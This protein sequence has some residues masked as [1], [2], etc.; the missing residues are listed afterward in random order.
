M[1][2]ICRLK[3]D[4]EDFIV[5][6]KEEI[7]PEDFNLDPV[8]QISLEELKTEYNLLPLI[9]LDEFLLRALRPKER[10]TNRILAECGIENYTAIT[11]EKDLI[12]QKKSNLSRSQRELVLKRYQEIV[13]CQ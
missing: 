2:Y 13:D 4:L 8:K 5:F 6:D 11:Y 10:T 9:K 1:F 12:N 7:K 3:E